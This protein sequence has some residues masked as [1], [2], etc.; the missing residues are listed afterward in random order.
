MRLI[1][2]GTSM[3]GIHQASRMLPSIAPTRIAIFRPSPV[4]VW[5]E[6]G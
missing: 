3:A 1:S 6:T 5:I 2:V 4:L